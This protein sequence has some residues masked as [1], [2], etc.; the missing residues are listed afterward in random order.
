MWEVGAARQRPAAGFG[1]VVERAVTAQQMLERVD[2]EERA[3]QA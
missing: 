3:E 2:P 1:Q